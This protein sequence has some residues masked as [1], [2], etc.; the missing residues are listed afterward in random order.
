METIQATIFKLKNKKS[1][2]NEEMNDIESILEDASKSYYNTSDLLMTDDEYDALAREFKR[3]GGVLKVGAEPPKDKGTI[4]VEHDFAELVGTLDKANHVYIKDSNDPAKKSV[5]EWIKWISAK[6]PKNKSF[7]LG[8]S[9]KFDGNSIVVE[10]KDGKVLKALTRG[11]NGQGMD[12]THVF[13]DHTIVSKEN[14]GI[15]YEVVIS[16]ENY[17]KLIED[18]G[19]SYANP[20]SLVS[21]KL[22]DDNAYQYYKYMEL[23][24]LWVKLKDKNMDREKQIEFIEENFGEDNSLLGEYTIVEDVEGEDYDHFIQHLKE[25]YDNYTNERYNLP[26]MIDGLV[27]EVIE[28]DVRQALGYADDQPRWAIALKFPSLKAKSR[29]TNF[30]FTLGP[31]G[32]ITPRVWYEPVDFNGSIHTKQSLQN[33]KRFAELKLGIGSDIIVSY[34]NDVLTYISKDMDSNK[35]VEPYPFTN[36]CPVCKGDVVIGESGAFAYCDNNACEGKVVGRVQNYLT[37]MDIKGI[38]DSTLEKLMLSGLLN[39]ITDLYTMDYSKIAS[40]EGLGLTT[41]INIKTAI[42]S[43]VPYD[44]EIAGALGINSF[45]ITKSKELFRHFSLKNLMERLFEDRQKLI[46]EIKDIEGF[47][48]ITASYITDGLEANEEVVSFLLSREHKVLADEVVQSNDDKPLKI[49]FTN[50]RDE[51]MQFELEKRGH[52]ITSSVSGKTDVVVCPDVNG[53]TVKIKTAKAKGIRVVNVEDFK[54][55][56]GL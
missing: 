26:H 56:M 46:E 52:K 41:G 35:E 13:K 42:N 30:D 49:V 9:F 47:S 12:L 1:V 33:Y 51:M 50:F 36:E 29:V 48:E 22:G 8:I 6:L 23:V 40:I 39:G 7:S 21:G 10:Y 2:S 28:E 19:L 38:K 32:I 18:T 17:R 16:W 34:S 54:K 3:L 53:N 15:K 20:R 55:E 43:K 31:S 14:V 44:Y 45:S 4:N 37:K 11:R 25:F 27:I 24:P 5:E